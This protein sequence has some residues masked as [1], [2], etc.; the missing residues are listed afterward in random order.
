MKRYLLFYGHNYYP[1]G[2]VSDLCNDFDTKEEAIQLLVE[3]EEKYRNEYGSNIHWANI[4]DIET[5][6][7]WSC[8]FIR[9][10]MIVD[11][12]E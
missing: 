5:G 11:D 2:G 8:E 4:L 10:E 3:Q 12:E 6:D 1:C 9:G 7:T